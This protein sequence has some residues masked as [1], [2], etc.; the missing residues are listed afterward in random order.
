MK[1][2]LWFIVLLIATTAQAQNAACTSNRYQQKVFPQVTKTSQ[3]LFGTATPYGLLAQPQNLY[4]DFYEPTGD[5]LQERPLIVYAFGGAFLIGDKNQPPIPQYCETLAKMGYAVAAIDYRIGFNTTSTESTIRAVYRAAQDLRAAIR[6]ICQRSSQY[7]IDTASII[8][9]GSSAGCFAGLHST[10]FEESQRPAATFGIL[11]EPAD[12]GCFDCS[13]NSDFGKRLPKIAGIVNHWGALL[14]TLLIENASDENCPVI[15]FHGTNDNLVPYAEGNPFS[16]PVFP[17]VYGSK[18][19]HQRLTSVGIVNKLYPLNGEGHEPWLLKPELVDTMIHNATDFL[20]NEVLRPKA[21]KI[22][23]DTIACKGQTLT[24]QAI[25]RNRSAYCWVVSP[26]GSIINNNGNTLTIKCIDTGWI[27]I[28]VIEKNYLN[29]VSKEAEHRIHIIEKPIANFSVQANQQLGISIVNTAQNFNT[30]SWNLGDG[31]IINGNINSYHYTL[32]G[33]YTIEQTVS[34][35]ACSDTISHTIVVDT[36]PRANFTY[37]IAGDTLLLFADT[38]NAVNYQWN[39]NGSNFSGQSSVALLF[40]SGTFPV[41]LTVVNQLG[42]AVSS[43][44]F[45]TK[46]ISAITSAESLPVSVHPNPFKKHFEITVGENITAHYEVW[47]IS[48][49]KLQEG[50][51]KTHTMVVSETIQWHG[52]YMLKV[53]AG[54]KSNYFKIL[55]E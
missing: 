33:T 38:T 37:R 13:G 23:G 30:I 16:Y 55:A 6:F 3:I 31:N 41:R 47:D 52:F 21:Q 53:T 12:L 15:S 20:Y 1:Q 36:C 24:L 7:K 18:N 39:I 9:T 22:S 48:G 46:E 17:S 45:I 8:L 11:T 5:S 32:P 27:T 2:F 42:C 51:F 43:L 40:N 34:N 44:Q 14:D 54:D 4:F 25:Q 19:I 29:T 35:A 10:Y 49:K 26:K 50:K 28:K